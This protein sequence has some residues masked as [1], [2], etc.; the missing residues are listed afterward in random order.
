ME[1]AE[2]LFL[3]G[4]V[5]ACHETVELPQGLQQFLALAC[6]LFLQ[7]QRKRSQELCNVIGKS[8]ISAG[9]C[10]RHHHSFRVC[11]CQAPPTTLMHTV[12]RTRLPRAS[13]T[14]SDGEPPHQTM[15]SSAPTRSQM[16]VNGRKFVPRTKAILF[17]HRR[18]T[19]RIRCW[20]RASTTQ[21]TFALGGCHV[22]Q[23]RADYCYL[24]L[25]SDARR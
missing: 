8:P 13:I 16:N 10:C 15:D 4:V 24:L 9:V 2:L 18:H 19:S 14:T 25:S 6:A 3:Q 17:A 5:G 1:C 11:D 21:P 22:G 7:L 23:S 12:R 20:A